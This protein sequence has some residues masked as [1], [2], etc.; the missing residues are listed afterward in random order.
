MD[1]G[2][3]AATATSNV[4]LDTPGL[5]RTRDGYVS[6]ATTGTATT[7]LH[8]FYADPN[9]YLIAD[10][11]TQMQ[12]YNSAGTHVAT[13]ACTGL[14]AFVTYGT[15]SANPA[16]YTIGR[17]DSSM[18]KFNGAAWSAVGGTAPTTGRG[19]AVTGAS[20]RLVVA[21]SNGGDRVWF[22]DPGA[23][24]TYGANNFVD[25]DPGNGEFITGACS[26][27]NDVYVFK[28]SAFYV[29]YGESI[30]S[31]G[32]PI[33][34]YRK[35]QGVGAVQSYGPLCPTP[36]GLYFL[37]DD[38]V[39]LTTG[40]PPVK[41]S[42]ALDQLFGAG[43][44]NALQTSL[45]VNLSWYRGQLFVVLGLITGDPR[46]FVWYRATNSWAEWDLMDGKTGGMFAA[47]PHNTGVFFCNGTDNAIYLMS[48]AATTDNG[49]AISWSYKSGRYEV[50]ERNRTAVIRQEQLTGTGTVNLLLETNL[51]NA[52]GGIYSGMSAATPIA[53]T[54]G[55]SDSA[56]DTQMDGAMGRWFQFTLSGTGPATVSELTHEIG[57]V[58]P[59][60]VY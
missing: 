47:N 19:L 3:T 16:V 25:L 13:V 45:N 51:Y 54:L 5:L 42:Q 59:A 14:H 27:A 56:T 26:W 36:Q 31:D 33:F 48:Q 46:V 55:T 24:E 37:A 53:Y 29:F 22:S 32:Q 39:Y 17:S 60:G 18:R 8:Y 23:P 11:A 38:G 7:R 43:R 34:N 52:A 49:S 10:Q 28:Q 4:A 2:A 57:N 9:P 6:F 20:N 1:V 50:A 58:M 21:G 40:G 15:A 44:S 30:D 12:A 35:V 41:V